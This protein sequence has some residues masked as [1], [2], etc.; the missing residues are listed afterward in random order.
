MA[1]YQIYVRDDRRLTPRL[2]LTVITDEIQL[3]EIARRVLAESDH[4]KAIEI[5]DQD[6][7]RFEQAPEHIT[8]A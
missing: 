2:R 3:T 6:G 1:S 7:R 5:F 8:G 4:Y